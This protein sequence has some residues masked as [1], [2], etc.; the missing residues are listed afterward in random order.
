MTNFAER[1]TDKVDKKWEDMKTSV[2]EAKQ[3]FKDRVL[4]EKNKAYER[5]V[6]SKVKAFNDGVDD[7]NQNMYDSVM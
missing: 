1:Q 3:D 2:N 4:S 6:Y 7:I 5:H